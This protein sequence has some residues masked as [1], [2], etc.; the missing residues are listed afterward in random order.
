MKWIAVLRLIRAPNLLIVALTQWL[1]YRQ[2]ILP[3]LS[4]AGIEPSLALNERLYLILVTV[5]ITA[6][7]YIINDLSDEKA[8]KVNGR[9]TLISSLDQRRY[10]WW[11]YLSGQILGF[12]LALFLAFHSGNR[13]WIGLYPAGVWLLYV[14][15]TV[16]KRLPFLG[17]V[18]IALFCAGAA[19]II[20]FAERGSL[21]QL[22]KTM[23]DVYL[24]FAGI[25][26]FYLGFAFLST[27]FREMIKDLEDEPGDEKAGYRTAVVWLGPRTVK[28]LTAWVGIFFFLTFGLG[29]FYLGQYFRKEWL[30]LTSILVTLLF[31]GAFRQVLKANSP[32]EFHLPSTLAKV[33]MALGILL[34]LGLNNI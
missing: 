14:Y 1:V 9:K 11:L 18:L 30:V 26:G 6:G 19:A 24:H 15:S 2:V 8:D 7:G 28:R 12:C 5:I 16:L 17:N 3:A 23:P 33:I 32:K 31:F 34:L 20:W 21:A 27:L 10:A 25:T 22:Q 29:M 4:A 13:L